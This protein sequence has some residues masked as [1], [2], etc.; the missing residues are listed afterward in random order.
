AVPVPE[1]DGIPLEEL[2]ELFDQSLADVDQR[3]VTGPAVTPDVLER[4]GARSGGRT[5][6]ANLALAENNA[7]VGADIATALAARVP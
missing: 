4:L 7:R 1:A 3:G 5:V 6:T 2:N